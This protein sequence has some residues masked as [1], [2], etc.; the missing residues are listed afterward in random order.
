MS[1]NTNQFASQLRDL[2]EDTLRT[3]LPGC[4]ECRNAAGKACFVAYF[5]SNQRTLT[6]A[7]SRGFR[8]RKSAIAAV[9]AEVDKELARR[10]IRRVTVDPLG[11]ATEQP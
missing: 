3:S 8:T 9:R 6:P 11:I 10:G 1:K 2:D 7:R 4:I 5:G